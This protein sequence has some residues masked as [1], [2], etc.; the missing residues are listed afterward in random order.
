MNTSEKAIFL[1]SVNYILSLNDPWAIIKNLTLVLKNLETISEINLKSDFSF[2]WLTDDKKLKFIEIIIDFFKYSY[3]NIKENIQNYNLIIKYENNENNNNNNNLLLTNCKINTLLQFSL[4]TWHWASKS[5]Y[6]CIKFH[7]LNGLRILFKYINDNLLIFHLI[8][9]LKQQT[10]KNNKYEKVYSNL[11]LV[12]KSIAGTIHN[13]SK[14]EP[15]YRSIWHD[16]NAYQHLL[17]LANLFSDNKRKLDIDLLAYFSIVNLAKNETDLISLTELNNYILKVV[18]LIQLAGFDMATNESQ[19]INRKLFKLT[20]RLTDVK[21]IAIVTSKENTQWRLTELIEF[22]I[23]ICDHCERFKLNTFENYTSLKLSIKQLLFNGNELEKEFILKLIWKLC[24]NSEN[25]RLFLDNEKDVC[26]FIIGLSYNK[27]IQNVNILK[28][29]DLI[30]FLFET[31]Q[32][33]NNNSG[34]RIKDLHC[35]QIKTVKTTSSE[36]NTRKMKF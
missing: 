10:I 23:R 17:N 22:M 1:N 14:F 4:I 18:D 3:E 13:L 26:S 9:K 20:D 28:Y 7:E 24:L 16:L 34:V 31:Q 12:Y 6:F 30:L 35:V 21:E 25:T 15:N 33:V 32:M 2:E 19:L 27:L 36:T 29:C 8:E 5:I 11:A